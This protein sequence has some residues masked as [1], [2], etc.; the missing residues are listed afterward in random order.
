MY[1]IPLHSDFAQRANRTLNGVAPKKEG[2][3]KRMENSIKIEN[4]NLD[5]VSGGV[6]RMAEM[7]RQIVAICPFCHKSFRTS[8]LRT[9]VKC[10]S[11]QNIV[12]EN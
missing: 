11:C 10:P 1:I 6:R 2:K 5:S 4:D 8:I 9:S 7:D 3:E 12:E